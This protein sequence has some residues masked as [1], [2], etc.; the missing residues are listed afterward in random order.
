VPVLV[1]VADGVNFTL[2]VQVA[3]PERLDPHVLVCAKLLLFVPAKL[4]PEMLNAVLPRFFM[5]T[6]LAALVVPTVRLA[7]V[8]VAGDR[9]TAVPVPLRLTVWGL[10]A[11]LSVTLRAAVLGP[12]A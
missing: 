10:P 7:K 5:V 4:K 2:I 1:P 3:P 12:T 6:L 8:I 9:E 11:A